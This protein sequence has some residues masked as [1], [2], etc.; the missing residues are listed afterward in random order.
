MPVAERLKPHLEKVLAARATAKPEDYLFPFAGLR[1]VKSIVGSPFIRYAWGFSCL[2][3]RHARKITDTHLH[4]WRSYAI[5]QMARADIPEDFR[6]R[7]VGHSTIGVHDGYTNI[8]LARLKGAE[9][10]IA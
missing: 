9:D 7:I 3:N 8:D 6:R 1:H 2:Y 5:S 10:T 4:C